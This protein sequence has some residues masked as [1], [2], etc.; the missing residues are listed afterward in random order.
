[1]RSDRLAAPRLW[2][3]IL[4]GTLMLATIVSLSYVGNELR[5]KKATLYLPSPRPNT[6]ILVDWP[7]TNLCWP[8][9]GRCC[10]NLNFPIATANNTYTE[11]SAYAC[12]ND[13]DRNGNI[14]CGNL[15]P[16]KDAQAC[17]AN[18][19]GWALGTGFLAIG[20]ASAMIAFI[21]TVSCAIG[22]Y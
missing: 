7:H 8:A 13:P 3:V 14:G 1:M 17:R 22:S 9:I 21:A 4:V 5:I 12:E 6:V 16:S 2:P 15:C 20:L 18:T 10:N 11:V 19:F